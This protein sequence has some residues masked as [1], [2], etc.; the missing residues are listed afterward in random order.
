MF[1]PFFMS[2]SG[3]HETIV[4]SFRICQRIN[5]NPYFT[6]IGFLMLQPLIQIWSNNL[7]TFIVDIYV[8]IYAKFLNIKK[9]TI[10]VLLWSVTSV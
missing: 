10:H 6:L 3:I 9:N 5:M 7:Y 1:R 2:S 4:I 8:I